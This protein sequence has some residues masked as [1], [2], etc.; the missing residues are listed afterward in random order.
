MTQRTPSLMVDISFDV[1]SLKLGMINLSYIRLLEKKEG[2]ELDYNSQSAQDISAVRPV[3]F[4]T[5]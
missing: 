3:R 1:R 4:C 5:D 2:Q